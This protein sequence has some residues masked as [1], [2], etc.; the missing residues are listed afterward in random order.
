MARC[1]ATTLLR[2]RCTREQ[3]ATANGHGYCGI[4]A[5]RERQRGTLDEQLDRWLRANPRKAAPAWLRG[6]A[7]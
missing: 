1:E 3:E 2:L 7:A 4:H 5:A 6:R